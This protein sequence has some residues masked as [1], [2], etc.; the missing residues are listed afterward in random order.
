[1]P[2]CE[3]RARR[4]VAHRLRRATH[5]VACGRRLACRTSSAGQR[6]L[7]V[8]GDAGKAGDLA[9]VKRQVRRASSATPVPRRARRHVLAARARSGPAARAATRRRRRP[10]ARPSARQ[11]PARFVSVVGRSPASLPPRSTSTRSLTAITSLSLCEMKMIESPL[12]TSSLQRARTAL[13]SRPASA[14]RSARRGSGCA[15]R[16]RAPSGSRPAAVRRPRARRPCASGSTARPKSSRQLRDAAARAGA[17]ERRPPQRARVPSAMFSSTVMLSA[18]VKCW[19]TMPMPAASAARGSP[20]GSGLPKTS[21]APLVGD[22]VAEQ[23]VHQRGLAGAV[24]AEQRDDLAA[25]QV[26]RDRVIGGQRA[27]ALGDAGDE[28]R[29]GT[30]DARCSFAGEGR[31]RRWLPPAAPIAPENGKALS[32]TSARRR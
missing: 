12:A 1:M 14:P 29:D 17:V 28:G 23:D 8:A 7:A 5:D 25:L 18:R 11:A 24:L 19:C 6:R 13:R 4:P 26:E 10:R 16:G 31:R 20:G 30:W 22:I 21:I 27:E 15:R 2:C 32:S 3:R 9:A